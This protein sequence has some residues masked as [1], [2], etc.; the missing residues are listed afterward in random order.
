[1]SPQSPT[2]FPTLT[3]SYILAFQ[4]S[5]WYPQF[6]NL[7]IKSTIIKP[8]TQQFCDYLD[9][10]RVFVPEGSE[11]VSVHANAQAQPMIMTIS[12]DPPKVRF[13]MTRATKM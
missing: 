7:S 11:D 6:S 13:P 3:P 9:A 1:M 10:D 5:S 4:F 12:L 2:L 8:L